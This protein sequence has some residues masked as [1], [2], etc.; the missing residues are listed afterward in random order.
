VLE[1]VYEGTFS[2]RTTATVFL[3]R[4]TQPETADAVASGP[5]YRGCNPCL[6]ATEIARH[7][8]LRER[9]FGAKSYRPRSSAKLRA[10]LKDADVEALTFSSVDDDDVRVS[11][12]GR[13]GC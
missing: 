1:A 2:T 13:S 11:S 6:A 12:W 7:T 8:A 5:R 9:D 3:T 4:T 10:E